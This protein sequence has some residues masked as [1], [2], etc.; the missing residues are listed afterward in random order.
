MNN[1]DIFNDKRQIL[2]RVKL[3]ILLT[4]QIPAIFLSLVIFYF[5]L[6]NPAILRTPQNCALFILLTVNFIQL[7]VVLPFSIHFYAL[8]YVSP[9]TS[10]Y[11]TSWTFLAYTVYVTGEYLM[12]T[13]SVQRHMLVFHSH[14][15]RIR[16]MRI[17]FHHSPLI[18]FLIYPAIFNI[19]VVLVYPCDGTQWDYTST[20]CGFANCY[21]VYDKVLG[22][23]DWSFNN[24][25]PMLINAL[26]NALLVIRVIRQKRQQQRPV[27][28]KQQR[29]MTVQLFCISS[30]YII[31]WGPSLIVG[32]IQILVDPTF[33]AEIQAAYFFLSDC[34]YLFVSALGMHWFHT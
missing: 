14:A 32:L 29:R 7:S 24:G 33:L 19:F 5:F 11:C 17:L 1:T 2:Y 9:A 31:G 12:A 13:I 22:T 10:A 18:L 21:L 34:H 23:F 27:T 30:L 6:K 15:L 25:L 4:L 26:A 8:G 16:W 3:S 20:V 28:W